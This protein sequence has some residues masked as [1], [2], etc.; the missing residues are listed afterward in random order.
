[1][2]RVNH[3][4]G[5]LLIFAG[6]YLLLERLCLIDGDIFLILLGVTF[7]SL[8]FATKRPLGLLIPGS[9]LTW[10]GLYALLIENNYLPFLEEYE[11]GLLFFALG[12]AFCTIFFHTYFCGSK[13]YQFWPLFPSLGLILFA[14]IVE[15][16]FSFIPSKYIFFIETYWP[17]LFIVLGVVFLIFSNKKKTKSE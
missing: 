17:V 13:G 3:L 7:I 4:F 15:F 9:I 11:G 8:Y 12:L 14:I 6:L 16:E 5:I 2:T 10:L 1:M